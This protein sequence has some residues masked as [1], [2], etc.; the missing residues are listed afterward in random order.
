[1]KIYKSTSGYTIAISK[2][3]NFAPYGANEM[4]YSDVTG[5]Y[6]QAYVSGGRSS[7]SG[8]KYSWESSFS[9]PQLHIFDK[10]IFGTNEHE[11]SG[12]IRVSNACG[13]E[14]FHPC[15]NVYVNLKAVHPLPREKVLMYD[16]KSE[17]S[18]FHVRVLDY[19]YSEG[20]ESVRFFIGY[21]WRLREVEIKSIERWRDGGTTLIETTDGVLYV[22]SPFKKDES[23]TWNG[24]KLILEYKK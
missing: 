15:E 11:P 21:N 20:F 19:K 2:D 4:L 7:S 10:K 1:M 3:N 12:V 16:L 17:T 14:F 24:E 9:V 22:P 6:Y 13:D 23:A 18:G 5:D 8:G